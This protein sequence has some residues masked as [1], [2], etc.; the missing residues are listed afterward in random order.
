MNAQD[1][2]IKGLFSLKNGGIFDWIFVLSKID[3][4]K[5]VKICGTDIALYLDFLLFS[6]KFFFTLAMINVV[7]MMPIYI[8]GDPDPENDFRINADGHSPIQALTILNV[9]KSGPKVVVSYLYSMLIVA[10]MGF[11]MILRYLNKFHVQDK[12]VENYDDKRSSNS[13]TNRDDVTSV[14]IDIKK[15]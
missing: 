14:L 10:P 7:I 12:S 1:R 11:W 9:T 3:D 5:L 13:I 4:E 8:S 2:G 6:A 15:L